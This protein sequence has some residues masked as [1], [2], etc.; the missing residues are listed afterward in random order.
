MSENV[1]T[2]AFD[3]KAPF[4]WRACSTNAHEAC[5]GNRDSSWVQS[6]RCGPCSCSCHV[7]KPFY[8]DTTPTSSPE[9]SSWGSPKAAKVVD[10]FESD[11]PE[12]ISGAEV[13]ADHVAPPVPVK[14]AEKIPASAPAASSPNY[15]NPCEKCGKPIAKSGKPGRPP[16][17]HPGGC[18]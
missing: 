8:V 2:P 15:P 13:P 7:G 10:P 9:T 1:V 11:E 18:P 3:L 4:V 12:E 14:A 16:R 5:H 6:H 17:Q